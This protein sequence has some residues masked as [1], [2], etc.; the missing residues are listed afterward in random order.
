[1]LNNKLLFD[2]RKKPAGLAY[3]SQYLKMLEQL[4]IASLIDK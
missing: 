3:I 4:L 1:M 2:Q